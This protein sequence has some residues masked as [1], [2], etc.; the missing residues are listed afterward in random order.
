MFIG[1]LLFWYTRPRSFTNDLWHT[2]GYTV[3]SSIMWL[4]PFQQVLSFLSLGCHRFISNFLFRVLDQWFIS[5]TR[6]NTW[7]AAQ[8]WILV[9]TVKILSVYQIVRYRFSDGFHLLVFVMLLILSSFILLQTFWISSQRSIW[10]R[11]F[12]DTHSLLRVVFRLIDLYLSDLKSL[13]LNML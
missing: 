13:V 4:G 10:T 7:I 11:I 5:L 6:E 9:V 3:L 1:A 8:V 2:L 12:Y